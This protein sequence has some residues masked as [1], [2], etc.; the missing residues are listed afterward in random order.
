MRP[1]AR[2]WPRR[3][4]FREG[5]RLARRIFLGGLGLALLVAA[6]ARAAKQILFGDLHVHTTF[7]FDAFLASLPIG[8][9][10]GAHPAALTDPA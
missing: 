7:S 3:G 9:G 1:R 2:N 10:E 5:G 6:G 4:A 8:S